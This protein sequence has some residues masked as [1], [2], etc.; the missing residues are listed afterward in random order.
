MALALYNSLTKKKDLFAP[1]ENGVVRMYTCGPTVYDYA[2][3]GNFR[4][5]VFEDILR[6]YL[7]LS[8]YRILQVM[9]ITDVDDKT[10]R[11][12]KEKGLPLDAYTAPYIDAFFQDLDTLRIERAEHY[13]RATMHIP[14]MVSL[15][16]K[17]LDEGYAYRKG[18][19]IYYS[20]ARFPR[21]GMLSGLDV[22]G[23]QH[24]VRV[25]T[26]EYEKED[27]RDFALW[28]EKGEE[29]PTWRT[30]IGEGRPGW[31]IECSAMSMKYLGESF[32]IHCGGIDNMFPH[33][34]NEIAQS[35]AATGKPFVRYWL[36]S[37]HLIV[38]GQKMSKS[39]GNYFT[40]RDLLSEGHDPSTLR[41]LLASGQY[42]TR[43]NFTS[44]GLRQARESVQ[45][46]RDFERR[47]RE[48][49]TEEGG[50]R[51]VEAMVL[52]TRKG[53]M[54][55]MDDDLNTPRALG[56]IFELIRRVN[57]RL[58]IQKISEGERMSILSLLKDFDAIFDVLETRDV[59]LEAEV[60]HLIEE[61]EQARRQGNFGVADRIREDL[62]KRGILLEDTAKGTRWKRA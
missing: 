41:Y 6:R 27:V 54:E 58:D 34:E 32:D 13:P 3:I 19:S 18:G 46:I 60:R 20:I 5:Y 26:D 35:E 29:E 43:L 31:H 1:L 22:E 53:F 33:H 12:A 4:T 15:I 28:K 56:E 36:H 37:E 17:L 11:G 30:E 52:E 8:G 40:L 59:T 49:E 45:R 61:R 10:I 21:Y 39:L 25:D 42:R 16:Q 57:A 7:E 24:G 51:E 50:A 9:N 48:A 47:V 55:A 2:H 23:L 38:E 44:E 14:E 62:K